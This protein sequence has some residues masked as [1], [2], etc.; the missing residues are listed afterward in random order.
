M[1]NYTQCVGIHI[2]DDTSALVLSLFMHSDDFISE[3]Y[4]IDPV[5]WFTVGILCS[6]DKIIHI[7]THDQFLKTNVIGSSLIS[8]LFEY[9]L[10][11]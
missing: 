10:P 7:S 6:C 4:E 8:K 5:R 11:L 9:I 1:E 3:I 2:I